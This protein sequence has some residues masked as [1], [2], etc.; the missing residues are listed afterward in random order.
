MKVSIMG[1]GVFGTFLE[2]LFKDVFQFATYNETPDLVILAIPADAYIHAA[3]SLCVRVGAGPHLV[4]VCSIQSTT[5]QTLLNHTKAKNVTS[6]HPLFGPRTPVDKRFAILTH[7]SGSDLEME[8]MVGFCSV[9]KI[10]KRMNPEEH[11]RL[12]AR[13]HAPFVHAVQ[14]IK[15]IVR[16]ADDIPDDEIPNSFRMMRELVK[17]VDDM[18]SGT[19]S[20]ILANPY[21]KVN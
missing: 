14:L 17:Q 16:A 7:S 19:I 10:T 21:W 15:P 5:T 11:D 2:E 1:S 4:N 12:M 18:P 6:V 3:R 9:A 20:S 8:F 13:T